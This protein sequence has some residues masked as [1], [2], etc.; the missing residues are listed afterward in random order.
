MGTVDSSQH[1]RE[2][3]RATQM[4]MGNF[5]STFEQDIQEGQRS[6]VYAREQFE[7]ALDACVAASKELN[8]AF[9]KRADVVNLN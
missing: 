1:A 6:V 7:R 4:E 2:A 3:L 5:S 8:N 9:K